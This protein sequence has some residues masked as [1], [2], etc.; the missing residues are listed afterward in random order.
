MQETTFPPQ[1]TINMPRKGFL[2]HPWE[3]QSW[4]ARIEGAN[5]QATGMSNKHHSQFKKSK[6]LFFVSHIP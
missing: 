2:K 3:A 6:P 1:H 4:K 5:P